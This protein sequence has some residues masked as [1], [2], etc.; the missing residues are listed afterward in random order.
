M[1]DVTKIERGK[2]FCC[3]RFECLKAD[4]YWAGEV[5]IL[6]KRVYSDNG[7]LFMKPG[8]YSKNAA[9]T[10]FSCLVRLMKWDFTN[11]ISYFLLR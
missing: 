10:F 6:Y 4:I 3:V 8:N 9:V 5:R 7:G 2:W 11:D 1:L